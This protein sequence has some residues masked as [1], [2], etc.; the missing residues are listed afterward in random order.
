MV[1]RSWAVDL[2]NTTLEDREPLINFLRDNEEDIFPNSA[3]FKKV[4]FPK[5]SR[6]LIYNKRWEVFYGHRGRKVVSI[7]AFIC[8]SLLKD[9]YD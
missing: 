6:A 2:T 7:D 3:L 5:D 9:I 1:N 4:T 8:S